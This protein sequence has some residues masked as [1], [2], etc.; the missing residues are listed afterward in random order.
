VLA[1]VEV[2]RAGLASGI[3]NAAARA[4]GLIAVAALPLLAGMGPEAYRSAAR[5]SET[6]GRA[7][8]ICAGVLVV[9]A[10]IAWCTVRSDAL[11]QA[12]PEAA[13]PPA[14]PPA[15]APAAEKAAEVT[16]EAAAEKAAVPR[17][18]C[19]PECAYH[20]GVGAPPL[21]PGNLGNPGGPGA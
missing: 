21:D 12:P 20:C 16:G 2:E 10:I 9:G 6:F 8:P 1:S 18:P 17:R 11:E 3:N 15:G 14:A 13:A 4:A 19:R 5:F 7:M